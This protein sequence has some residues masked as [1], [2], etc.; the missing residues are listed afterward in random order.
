MPPS[1]LG[2]RKFY[3]E[4]HLPLMQQHEDMRMDN[5]ANIGPSALENPKKAPSPKLEPQT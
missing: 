4:E 1:H 2:P 5:S 3:D